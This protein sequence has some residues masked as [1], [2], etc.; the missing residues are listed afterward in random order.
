MLKEIA[1][2]GSCHAKTDTGSSIYDE[3]EEHYLCDDVCLS[4]WASE[5]LDVVIDRYRKMHCWGGD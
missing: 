4:D 1:I 3:Q 5:H 2:C